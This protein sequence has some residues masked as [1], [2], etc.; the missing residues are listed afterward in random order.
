MSRLTVAELRQ[1]VVDK[2]FAMFIS[3]SAARS[4]RSVADELSIEETL[5]FHFD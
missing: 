3:R 4:M 5:E 1:S 2:A